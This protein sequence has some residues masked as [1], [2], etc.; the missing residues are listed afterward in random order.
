MSSRESFIALRALKKT[1]KDIINGDQMHDYVTKYGL[2]FS[3]LI[4]D[5][6]ETAFDA[7][8]NDRSVLTHSGLKS[9]VS[10]FNLDQFGVNYG[11]RVAIIFGNGPELAV[12]LLAVCSKW[13]AAPINPA[14]PAQEILAEL[15]STRAQV[16]VIQAGASY[17]TTLE[18]ADQLG[19]GVLLLSPSPTVCGMFTLSQVRPASHAVAHRAPESDVT[20]PALL[21]HTSGT[22]GNKKLVPYYRDTLLVGVACIIMSWELCPTD[23]CLNMMPLFH[24]GGIVRNLLAPIMAGGTVICCGSF[25]ACLFWDVLETQRVTWYYAAPTMHHAILLEAS[26]RHGP[27]PTA[28]RFLANA[29][30]GLSPSLAASLKALFRATVLTSYGMTE[31]MPISTPPLHS[32]TEYPVGTSGVVTGPQLMIANGETA[33]EV[34]PLTQGHILVRGPPCFRGYEAY[35]E[36]S[37]YSLTKQGFLSLT[38]PQ[39]Q[40]L[41]EWFDTGDVGHVDTDGYLFISGRSKEIINRGGETVSPMEVEEALTQ[42]PLVSQALAFAAPHATLQET[43]GAVLVCEGRRPSLRLLHSFLESRLNRSKWPQVLLFLSGG[44]PKNAVGKVLRIGLAQRCDLANVDEEASQMLRIYEGECP[45]QGAPLTSKIDVRLVPDSLAPVEAVLKELG[46]AHAAAIRLSQRGLLQDAVVALVAPK[47]LRIDIDLE[48]RMHEY[49]TPARLLYVDSL[50]LLPDGTLDL[51]TATVMAKQALQQ[52]DTSTLPRN[53]LETELEALWKTVLCPEEEGRLSVTTSFFALGGDSLLAGRLV[54]SMRRKMGVSLSVADL[55]TAP[56]IEAIGARIATLRLTQNSPS[57]AASRLMNGSVESSTL[58]RSSDS[59][60]DD[61]DKGVL[62]TLSAA[63]QSNSLTCLVVQLLPMLVLLPLRGLLL[64]FLIAQIWVWAMQWGWDRFFALVYAMVAAR[65]I[66]AI[67]SPMLGIAIKWLVIGRYQP[68]LYPLWSAMYL[69]WWLVETTQK[70]LGKGVFAWDLPLIGQALHPLYY[71]LQGAK[72]GHNVKIHKNARLGQADLLDIGSDVIIDD[73]LVRP[74]A[75]EASHMLLSPIKIGSRCTVGV[76][77]SIA[78]GAILPDGT[79]VGPLSSSHEMD[80][81][82]PKNAEYCRMGLSSPPLHLLFLVG[83]PLLGL[84]A[85]V[86]L[87]PWM[88]IL[89]F[90]LQQAVLGGWYIGNIDSLYAACIWWVTPQ[91]LV[92]YFLLRVVRRCIMPPVRLAL[93]ICIKRFVLGKFTE[94]SFGTD[95]SLLRYWLMSRLLANGTISHVAR[96]IG[97]HYEGVS[98]IYRLLGAKVGLRVYW[99]GSGLDLIE[100]DLLEVGDDVVFG[101]RSVLI[102]SSKLCAKKIRLDAGCMVADRCVV[103]PG[104]HL[105]RGSVAGSGTLTTEDFVADVGSLWLGSI[106]GEPV[107]V[108]PADSSFAHK[109]TKSAFG[110]AFY[111]RKAPYYVLPLGLVVLY[112]FLWQGFVV[113][114]HCCPTVLSVLICHR[115]LSTAM[116]SDALPAVLFFELCLLCLIPV[117]FLLNLGAV[118][119]DIASKWLLLGRRQQGTYPWDE[120]PYCQRWQMYLTLQEIRRG[121]AEHTGVLDLITGSEYLCIY[122]RALGAVIGRNVCLYPNGGDPMMTE[123]DLVSIGDGASVDDASL[124]AHINTRGIFRLNPLVV[125]AGCVLKSS[126]RLLS[127]ATMEPHSILLE[128]TLVLTGELVSRCSV[129]QG[130]PCRE[131]IRLL[132]YRGR[133]WAHLRSESLLRQRQRRLH[134]KIREASSKVDLEAMDCVSGARKGAASRRAAETKDRSSPKKVVTGIAFPPAEVALTTRELQPLLRATSTG[135]QYNSLSRQEDSPK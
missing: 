41:G 115:T 19:L 83:F 36:T 112:N 56:T 62:P 79:D 1:F 58:S 84:V 116:S 11:A 10:N 130:W 37:G 31:C 102:P 80:A 100:H 111:D 95:W 14:S 108:A 60:S 7:P 64:W 39:G 98:I 27:A 121:E 12:C 82:D 103:L 5:S 101:S 42:H 72:I 34:A 63:F 25:D 104:T 67:L 32:E 97:T 125:G 123:P 53:L 3:E 18:V 21:L 6:K 2:Q 70:V 126:T 16:V 129:W 75:L 51:E 105:K 59:S 96:L 76:K 4:C 106:E 122:F 65:L 69:K 81:A 114:Y 35:S 48:A 118:S 47:R 94:E 109:V 91:R 88:I 57:P 50:P 131:Q 73:A 24:I 38:G 90:M 134:N 93:V 45:K 40:D 9:F 99:P 68:G 44:V 23:V 92:Y 107:A 71:E 78:P 43:V 54:H 117:T 55:F 87:V 33:T 28:L 66:R 113:C 77:S 46:A 120:S 119:V 128:H 132:S 8:L 110:R 74:F 52:Q 135:V 22:S 127:G 15:K 85:A 30:G 13:C 26:R 20:S 29:A 61:L 49:E 86:T 133:M 124:I 89:H 17:A